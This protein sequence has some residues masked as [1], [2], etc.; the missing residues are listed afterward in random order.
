MTK[1]A[2]QSCT[3]RG[4]VQDEAEALLVG[5]VVWHV[6]S[7]FSYHIPSLWD[8]YWET[9]RKISLAS[10]Q[11]WFHR[12]IDCC[13]TCCLLCN[14]YLSQ[15]RSFYLACSL[16]IC[17]YNGKGWNQQ[18]EELAAKTRDLRCVDPQFPCVKKWII[19][20]YG[21]AGRIQWDYI[22]KI[23]GDN[24]YDS[25]EMPEIFSLV[26]LFVS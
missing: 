10:L 8:Y 11:P 2:L 22:H 6:L 3:F 21:V 9:Q 15:W 4:R 23:Y 5:K 24:N 17:S 26:I 19:T 16:H 13:G 25:H 7:F 12:P 14:K 18:P 1:L 20:T